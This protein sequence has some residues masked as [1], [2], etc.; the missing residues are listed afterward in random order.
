MKMPG[1]AWLEFEVM[2]DADGSTIRQTSIFDPVGLGGLMYWY[3][4][5]PLH[6]L[7]FARMLRNI[8]HAAEHPQGRR[9]PSRCQPH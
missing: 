9:S 1:R 5:Y 6:Q 7:V 3:L 2:A 8:A 4:V